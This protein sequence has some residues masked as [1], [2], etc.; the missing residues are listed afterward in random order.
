[1]CADPLKL[2]ATLRVFR[3]QKIDY[4]HIDIMDGHFVPNFALGTDYCRSLRSCT[5]IPLDIHLMTEAPEDKLDWF[6][7]GEND[8]VSVHAESTPHLQK[9][10]SEI[11]KRGAKAFAALNPATN[12]HAL[13]YVLDDLDGVVIMAVNPGFAGQKMIPAVLDKI[14]DAR[15]LFD[16][17]GHSRLSV[18]VDGNV[19]FRN[20][21][22]MRDAGADIF[23]AGTSSVFSPDCSLENGI[24]RFRKLL[25]AD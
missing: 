6:D 15:S 1:M 22:L 10:L 16:G 7:F 13:E 9:A 12:L 18:E 11:R 14:R 2:E 24:K 19:S 8:I 25:S 20:A 23:V 3:E 17:S 21:V 5:D 4:L